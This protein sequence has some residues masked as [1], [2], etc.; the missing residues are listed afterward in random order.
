MN[1]APIVLIE[2]DTDDKE[3][4][5]MILQDLGIRNSLIWF[6]NGHDAYEYLKE[7]TEQPFLI[8]SDVNLP[9]MTGVEFKKKVDE[10]PTLSKKC[11]PFVLYSTSVDKKTV[12]DAYTKMTVQGFFKKNSGYD[13]IKKTIRIIHEYWTYCQ[14][15][16]SC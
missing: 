7:T 9:G 4:L 5:E 1:S 10:H 13:D 15:P 8:L 11:I 12:E 3:I 6:S 2:D 16:N 14:H